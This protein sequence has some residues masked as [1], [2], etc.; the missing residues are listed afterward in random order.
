MAEQTTP[1]HVVTSIYTTLL[2]HAVT[3]EKNPNF[4]QY[5]FATLAKL[6]RQQGWEGF[7]EACDIYRHDLERRFSKTGVETIDSVAAAD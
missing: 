1:G 3:Q 7:P 2:Q 5:L 4:M 6:G